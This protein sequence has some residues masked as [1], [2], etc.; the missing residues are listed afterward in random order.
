MSEEFCPFSIPPEDLAEFEAL[1]APVRAGVLK[2]LPVVNSVFALGCPM[3]EAIQ[4]AARAHGLS[5]AAVRE[6]Y[7]S[8]RR[9]G[10]R[11]LILHR[12]ENFGGLGIVIP[13]A[14]RAEFEALPMV[15]RASV[16]YWRPIVNDVQPDGIK[17]LAAIREAATLHRVTFRT[18]KQRYYAAK[19]HGWR[20]LVLQNITALGGKS[21]WALCMAQE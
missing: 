9:E 18:L 21:I 11:G 6:R 2:S 3:R 16:I 8:A 1:P 12:L 10:W 19:N 17:V 7:Y 13:E 15:G 5:F 14:D 4:G 20:G